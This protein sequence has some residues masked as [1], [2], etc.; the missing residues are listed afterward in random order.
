[1]TQT[2]STKDSSL[3]VF[4]LPCGWL[5]CAFLLFSFARAERLPVK[6]YTTADGLQRDIISRIRQD[7][8][9]FLWFC[10]GEGISRFD[11][12][13]MTNFTVTDGLP[14]RFVNDFLEAK[15][16]TIYLATRKGLARLNPHG[17]RG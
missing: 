3:K 9:G 11:G 7:S 16:G 5:L 17:L 2:A 14:N 1:M 10:T 8:R 12:V 6:T 15:N 13:E 4:F